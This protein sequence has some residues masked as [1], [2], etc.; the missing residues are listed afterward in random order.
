M[1]ASFVKDA[2]FLPLYDFSSLVKNKVFVGLWIYIWV[3]DSIALVN[4]S[5]FVPIP[6]SSHYCSS[7]IQFEV[8]DGN[9]SRTTFLYRIVLAILGFLFCYINLIIVLSRS[10][11][12]FVGI[13][14]GIVLNL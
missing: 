1:P 8:R 6:G 9:A 7:V 5:V 4:I 14:M 3:F 13:L 10:L 11:K 12:N 2:F